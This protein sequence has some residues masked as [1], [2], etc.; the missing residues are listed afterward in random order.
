MSTVA[1]SQKF[2][3]RHI[4]AVSANSLHTRTLSVL[5]ERFGYK[6]E[7][8]EAGTEA[9][10]RIRTARPGLVICDLVLKD[11]Q[12]MDLF[13][14]LR[15]DASTASIPVVFM[16]PPSDAAMEKQCLSSGAEACISRPVQAEE[17]YRTVQ[18]IL[19]LRPRANIRIGA[20]LPVVVNNVPLRCGGEACLVDLSE[21]GMHLPMERPAS[22]KD[23]I[24]IQLHIKDRTISTEGKVLYSGTGGSAGGIGLQFVMLQPQ[25]RDFIRKFIR[26]EVTRDIGTATGHR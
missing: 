22:G 13:D 14:L 23:L 19:E 12:G 3:S 8:T 4:V 25:D 15:R 17:L 2:Q 6:V 18:T 9:A 16:T 11:M 26:E 20:R 7:T 24:S 1:S 10:A 21:Q 5:L